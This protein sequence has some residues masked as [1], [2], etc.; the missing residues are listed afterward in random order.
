MGVAVGYINWSD[1]RM[2]IEPSTTTIQC[3]VRRSTA[4]KSSNVICLLYC[5]SNE[6]IAP[7]LHRS[8]PCFVVT[9]AIYKSLAQLSPAGTLRVEMSEKVQRREPSPIC[10]HQCN[11]ALLVLL[12]L[13]PLSSFCRVMNDE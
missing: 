3:Q 12:L 13:I 8:L 4:R 10:S 7:L 1:M 9:L 5:G 6:I 11:A 2:S